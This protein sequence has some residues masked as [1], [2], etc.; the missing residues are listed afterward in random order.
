MR[1]G[2]SGPLRSTYPPLTGPAWASFMTGMTPAR[3]GV[4]EFFRRQPGTYRQLLNSYRDIDGRP[5]GAS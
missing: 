2:I 1:G 5:S 4:L 3:H